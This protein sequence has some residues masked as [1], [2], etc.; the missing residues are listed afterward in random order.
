MT[1]R[2]PEVTRG[3][4]REIPRVKWSGTVHEAHDGL[5]HEFDIFSI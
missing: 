2:A 4:R 5:V 1:G 3:G